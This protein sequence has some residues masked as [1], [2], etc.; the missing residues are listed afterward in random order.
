MNNEDRSPDED[1]F[2]KKLDSLLFD[3]KKKKWYDSDWAFTIVLLIFLLGMIVIG[4]KNG[5]S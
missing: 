5:W 4:F 3:K 2:W 1:E